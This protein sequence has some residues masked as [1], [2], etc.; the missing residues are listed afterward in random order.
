M[1]PLAVRLLLY[2]HESSKHV[3]IGPIRISS[4]NVHRGLYRLNI[5]WY[6]FTNWIF[7]RDLG[8]F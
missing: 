7:G 5:P 4:P 6:W 3:R 8:R 1:A 2:G